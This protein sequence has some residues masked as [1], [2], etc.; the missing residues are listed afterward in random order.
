[1]VGLPYRNEDRFDTAI[2]YRCLLYLCNH[3]NLMGDS[4]LQ[5]QLRKVEYSPSEEKRLKLEVECLEKGKKSL[6]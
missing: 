3:G 5:E 2:R 1:M 6:K 4:K